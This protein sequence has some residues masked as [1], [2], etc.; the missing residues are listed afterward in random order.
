MLRDFPSVRH[1]SIDLTDD[2]IFWMGLQCEGMELTLKRI[3]GPLLFIGATD[4]WLG[5]QARIASQVL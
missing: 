3:H 5:L 2:A 1:G 4:Q